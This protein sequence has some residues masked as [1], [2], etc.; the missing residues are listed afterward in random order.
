MMERRGVAV[1]ANSVEHVEY[2]PGG[3][4]SVDELAQS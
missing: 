3:E 2:P 1:T 4:L